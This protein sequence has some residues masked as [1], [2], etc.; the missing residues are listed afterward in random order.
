VGV[1]RGYL[2]NAEKV[3]VWGLEVDGNIQLNNHFSLYGNLAY[4]DGKYVSFKNAPL[5]LEETGKTVPAPTPTNPSATKSVN[6]KD[7]SGGVLPGISKW[8]VSF[9]GEAVTG[10]KNSLLG[11]Q[12]EYFIATDV[13]YR[14]GFS[15]SPSP[16]QFL[17]VDAYYL[18]NGRLGFR[19]NNGF[20]IFAWGRNLLNRNYFEQLLPAAGNAGHFA[21]VLGDPSNYGITLRYKL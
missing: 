7:I 1:N 15:S 18:I 9:G 8:V 17:N 2:A 11:Q 6:F 12:G 19:S 13:Y 20:S 21:G 5:P 3:R 4:T 16:S 10:N 14:S